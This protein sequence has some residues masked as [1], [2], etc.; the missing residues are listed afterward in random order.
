[1]IVSDVQIMDIGG[2]NMLNLY[3][4]TEKTGTGTRQYLWIESGGEFVNSEGDADAGKRI[5]TL[6]KDFA[7]KIKVDQITIELEEQEKALESLDKDLQKLRKDKDSLH[8]TIEDAQERIA[9]AEE[10]ILKNIQDQE[11][12]L[13]E[14][15]MQREVVDEVKSRIENVRLKK[16]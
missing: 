4:R 2:A 7:H 5:E 1:M 10:D 3:T 8:K 15:E 14:I 12:S 13:K 6:L 9:K 16:S 11:I